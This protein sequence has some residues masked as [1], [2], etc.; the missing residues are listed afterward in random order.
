MQLRIFL[1]PVTA[2]RAEER[3]SSVMHTIDA[4]P[5]IGAYAGDDS[6]YHADTDM[7][8]LA[9]LS[10]HDGNDLV[11]SVSKQLWPQFV[12][13]NGMRLSFDLAAG[14]SRAAR[15]SSIPRL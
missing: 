15:P 3:R 10:Q 12:D 11:V 5:Q 6:Q 14:V 9:T 2:A 1:L 8:G 13:I 7:H 4:D